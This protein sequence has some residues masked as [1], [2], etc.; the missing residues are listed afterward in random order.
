MATYKEKR[1][2][3]VVPIVSAVPST[4][5]NGEIVY[6]TGQ[7]LASYNGG[8][9]SKLTAVAAPNWTATT[10]QAKVQSSDIAAGDYF[11][12]SVAIDG[13]TMVAGAYREDTGGDQTGAAYVFT[14]SGTTWS[15]Q[16]KIQS[17]DI[18]EGDK[19][20]YSVAIDGNTIVVGAYLEDTGAESAGAAYIFTR[21]GTTWSQ[22][23]KLQT[24][25]ALASDRFGEVVAIDGDTMVGGT[26]FVDTGG[27]SAGAAYVL[28][29][30]QSGTYNG[31]NKQ[32]S[33]CNG[34]Y[35]PG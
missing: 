29:R 22:Q 6:I 3:N 33:K 14:R 26:P 24:S 25:D 17:S 12:R 35:K 1:G 28:L 9:W 21:S 15:Q 11:G 7:G 18:A 16:A 2:T 19:F 4:G 8:T 27:T 31:L 32:K 23:A 34:H 20:G 10:Q 30:S 13:N 5:V